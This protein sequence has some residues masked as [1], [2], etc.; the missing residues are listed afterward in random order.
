[1]L[2]FEQM[3]EMLA[4]LLVQTLY[5]PIWMLNRWVVMVL[6]LCVNISPF[7]TLPTLFN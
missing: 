7:L 5:V 3:V 4:R 1:M 2:S 6:T